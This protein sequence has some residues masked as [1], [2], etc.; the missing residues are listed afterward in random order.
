MASKGIY[1]VFFE[2]PCHCQGVVIHFYNYQRFIII[3]VIKYFQGL[4]IGHLA[5]L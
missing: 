3:F 2:T 4:Q 1:N 5:M